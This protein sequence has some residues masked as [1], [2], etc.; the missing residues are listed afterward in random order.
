MML[1]DA[2]THCL[3]Y[4]LVIACGELVVE[5]DVAVAAT[6]RSFSFLVAP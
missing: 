4:R 5:C 6:F 1:A 3:T 2:M